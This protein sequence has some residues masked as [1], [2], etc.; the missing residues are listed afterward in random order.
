MR[1]ADGRND[2]LFSAA[3][4]GVDRLMQIIGSPRDGGEK[5]LLRCGQ[6]EQVARGVEMTDQ[7]HAG[8]VVRIHFVRRVERDLHVV[9]QGKHLRLDTVQVR[10]E[11]H[12]T[13][14]IDR[15]G[16][17]ADAHV[18]GRACLGA[19]GDLHVA[20]VAVHARDALPV[21]IQAH[22]RVGPLPIAAV[23]RLDGVP[24]R[25]SGHA[26][27]HGEAVTEPDVGVLPAPVVLCAVKAAP[28]AVIG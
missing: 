9:V 10:A 18:I 3:V 21:Q 15:V 19:V 4:A 24:D 23:A 11:A 5:F 6:L 26:L 14:V 1:A 7:V 25:P 16:V 27:R 8:K 17:A 28:V 13:L 22:L 20:V 12:R 2:G